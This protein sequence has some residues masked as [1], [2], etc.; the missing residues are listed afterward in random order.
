MP[1]DLT[2]TESRQLVEGVRSGEITRSIDIRYQAAKGLITASITL[3]NN[4]VGGLYCVWAMQDYGQR[5][6]STAK[7]PGEFLR[8]MADG[9][10][11]ATPHYQMTAGAMRGGIARRICEGT[12]STKGAASPRSYR[13]GSPDGA[14]IIVR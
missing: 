1:L 2:P 11:S 10:F 13:I 14:P 4:D 12:R 8:L 7:S 9:T 5:P 6:P 3:S